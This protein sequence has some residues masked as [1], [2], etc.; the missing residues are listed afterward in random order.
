MIFVRSRLILRVCQTAGR[1]SLHHLGRRTPP[2]LPQRFTRALQCLP[3]QT[4]GFCLAGSALVIEFV[5]ARNTI[6]IILRGIARR[7]GEPGPFMPAFDGML[8][9]NQIEELAAYVRD[10]FTNE[11]PWSNIGDE[12]DKIRKGNPS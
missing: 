11:S 4:S 7:P 10:R 2:P 9:D 5:A 1:T 8:S 12:I 6:N 3:R